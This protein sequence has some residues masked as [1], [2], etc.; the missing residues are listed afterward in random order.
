MILKANLIE[1]V[2]SLVGAK[3]RSLL[4][5][6]GIVVG[7]GSVIAMVSVGAIVKDEALANSW[8][9]APMWSP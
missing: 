6:I 8:T 7:I 4:A 3:Q 1:A 5:L 9:W 2:N